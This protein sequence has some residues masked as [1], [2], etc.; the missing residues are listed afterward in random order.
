MFLSF[1]IDNDAR[2]IGAV[3]SRTMLPLVMVGVGEVETTL[4]LHK[5]DTVTAM[6]AGSLRMV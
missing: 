5:S 4:H 3:G 1:R 2:A 6:V